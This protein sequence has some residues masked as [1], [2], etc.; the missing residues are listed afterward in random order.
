MVS[1]SD[2]TTITV[3]LGRINQTGPNPNEV[4]RQVIQ[5]VCHPLYDTSTNDN[6]MC[7]LKLSARVAYTNY[8][9][10][11]CLAA[12]NSSTILSGTLSWLIGWGKVDNGKLPPGRPPPQRADPPP[13]AAL[14][15]RYLPFISPVGIRS[16]LRHP[17]G[18]G[19]ARSGEQPVQ[20]HLPPNYPQHALCRLH[21]G[22]QGHLPGGCFTGNRAK[23]RRSSLFF[24]RPHRA[25]LEAR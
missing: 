18:G 9:S 3:Y 7:L 13:A 22:G 20:M 21:L 12:A 1:H 23:T 14:K 6:D 2:P 24:I 10:P 11:V 17:P 4:S 25:T 5:A 15:R 19:G 16:S 8:I